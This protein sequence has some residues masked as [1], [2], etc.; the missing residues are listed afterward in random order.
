[1]ESFLNEQEVLLRVDFH[2]VTV[3]PLGSWP[4]VGLEVK[5]NRT[6]LEFFFV[7]LLF[8]FRI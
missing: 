3:R 2:C 5:I 8:F 4:G 7:F 1:M 6:S